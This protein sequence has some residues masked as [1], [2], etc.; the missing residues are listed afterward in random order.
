MTTR[1]RRSM[2][3]LSSMLAMLAACGGG[4]SGAEPGP[5][6]PPP[7]PPVLSDSQR[8]AAATATIASNPKCAPT[9]LAAYYWEIGDANG[10][11]VSGSVGNGV[12]ASTSLWLFSSS[13]WLYAANVVQ[14]HGV[15]AQD[16]PFLNFTS[17]YSTFGNAPICVGVPTVDGCLVGRD[18]FDPATE[19]RFAYDSG[20]MQHH[21]SALMN[22]GSADNAALAADLNATVGNFSFSYT[23]PQL[24]AGVVG[25]PQAYAGFL[26][27]LLRGELALA[28]ALG[29]H[30][31]CAQAAAPGCN[32]AFTPDSI[33]TEAWNYSL[34]H[35][36]E[37]DPTV[38]DHAFSSAGGGGFYPWIDSSKTYYGL[39]ARD[40]RTEGAAGYHSAECGR[41]V[42]QAWTTGQAVTTATPTPSR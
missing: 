2:V 42:R 32:A 11:K 7:P 27:R 40:T 16:V 21:A 33:G 6:S 31:V 41:L 18:G 20:H 34:G 29:S 36:V 15:V 37:D 14:K 4:G 8:A 10:A 3:A 12:T 22:L 24:A 23:V 35:W 13:K 38:G 39:I 25:T 26:R 30:K 17:G 19:T 9:T 28:N 1:Q 5:P